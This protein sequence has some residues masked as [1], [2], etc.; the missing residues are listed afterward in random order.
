MSL[1][2]KAKLK[3]ESVPE[4]FESQRLI[5]ETEPEA[6]QTMPVQL[7]ECVRLARFH[8]S[9]AEEEDAVKLFFHL[10]RASASLS[11]IAA[12]DDEVKFNGKDMAKI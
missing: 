1:G 9:R 10:R 7:H 3:W 2:N 6:V 8:E 12:A 11:N 5:S 4:R